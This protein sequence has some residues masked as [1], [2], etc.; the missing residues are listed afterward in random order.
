MINKC[1]LGALSELKIS[2][3]FVRQGW[4]MYY[5]CS[6]DTPVDIVGIKGPRVKRIQVKTAYS[7]GDII[8]ANIDHKK[9]AKYSPDSVDT[10]ACVYD[11]SLMDPGKDRI[12]LIPMEDI[13][14]ITTLNLGKTDGS[15]SKTRANFKPDSYEV[16]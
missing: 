15:P 11:N 13:E 4:V 5:P 16:L 8:R 3:H 10:L 6:H 2:T 1:A 9:S 14:G 12:W 7:C